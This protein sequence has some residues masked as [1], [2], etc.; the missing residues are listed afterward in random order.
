MARYRIELSE[1]QGRELR[2]RAE[3]H[4][5]PHREVAGQDHAVALVDVHHPVGRDLDVG[6][7]Q[8]VAPEE[9]GDAWIGPVVA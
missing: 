6:S 4:T 7:G 9:N 8:L 3:Q 2:R 5:R 1:A